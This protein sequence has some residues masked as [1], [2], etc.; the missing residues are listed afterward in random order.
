MVLSGTN[1]W[2]LAL[3]AY[4]EAFKKILVSGPIPR[5][6]YGVQPGLGSLHDSPGVSNMPS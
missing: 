5:T 2:L 1:E 6:E 4:W 3:I